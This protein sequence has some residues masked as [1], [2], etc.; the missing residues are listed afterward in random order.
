[1]RKLFTNDKFFLGAVLIA[2]FGTLFFAVVNWVYFPELRSGLVMDVLSALCV[3]FLYTSYRKHSKNVMKCIIGALLM[4]VLVHPISMLASGNA[5]GALAFVKVFSVLF[6]AELFINHLIINSDHHSNPANVRFNQS[7]CIAL[8]LCYFACI[9]LT[10][11]Y[12]ETALCKCA[13]V[14]GSVAYACVIASVVCVESR[15]D[16]Y[17]IAREEKGYKV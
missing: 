6:A 11:K 14:V 3:L 8:A 17:R 9:A 16:A 5:N 1:M 12:N 2:V 10:W 13:D 15:L 4:L 7:L